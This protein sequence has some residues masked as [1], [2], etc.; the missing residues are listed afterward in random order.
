[1]NEPED[2]ISESAV[3]R[4]LAELAT[5]FRRPTI[6]QKEAYARFA[7]TLAAAGLI[8]A[9]ALIFTELPLS[10]Y[11]VVRAVLMLL[12]GLVLFLYG[13]LLSRGE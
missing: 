8:G 2:E 9:G 11:V 4:V 10:A 12:V 5:A 1:V 6:K 3:Q 7:H 13:T